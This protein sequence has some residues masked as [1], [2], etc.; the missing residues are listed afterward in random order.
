M[1]SGINLKNVEPNTRIQDDLFRHVNGKWLATIKISDDRASEGVGYELFE[2]AER[3]VRAIIEDSAASVESSDEEK[4]IGALF[5]SFMN[6]ERIE[7]LGIAPIQGYLDKAAL[8][9]DGDS[10]LHT[11]SEFERDGLGGLFS[12]SVYTDHKKSDENILYL[13]QGGL[14]L[15][16]EALLP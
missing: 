13:S 11:L 4:K 3:Q 14:S 15:P 10:L 5:A 6:T 8:I 9:N 1:K 12:A 7:E 2:Q 16:D